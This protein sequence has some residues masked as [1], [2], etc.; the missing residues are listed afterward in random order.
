MPPHNYIIDYMLILHAKVCATEDVHTP[1]E[2]VSTRVLIPEHL[3]ARMGMPVVL[4]VRMEGEPITHL[5]HD[6]IIYISISEMEITPHATPLLC[7][8]HPL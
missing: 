5:D 7:I 1:T 8:S 4:W 6:L 2:A 3:L